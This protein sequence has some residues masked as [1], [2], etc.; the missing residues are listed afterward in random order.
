MVTYNMDGSQRMSRPR[1]GSSVSSGFR[2]VDADQLDARS[3]ISRNSIYKLRIDSMFDDTRSIVSQRLDDRSSHNGRRRSSSIGGLSRG[4]LAGAIINDRDNLDISA[5]ASSLRDFGGAGGV[6]AGK[7]GPVVAGPAAGPTVGTG[8]GRQ[9]TADGRHE[10]SNSVQ[11]QIER[12]FTDVAKEHG[13]SANVQSFSVRCLGSLPLKEKVTSLVGLQEPLRQLYLSGAGHG[14]QTGG[15]LDISP[16]GL[17]IRAGSGK[18][19]SVTPFQNIA[20]WSAVK[21]VVSGAEGGAAFLPLI[22]DPENIDKSSLFRPLSAAD[23]RRLSSGIHSP[24]FAIVMR[25]TL[26]PRQLEC[27]GFVCQ[28]P[29]DAIVIAATLYQSL[30][31]HMSGGDNQRPKRPKNRNGVSCMSIASSTVTTNTHQQSGS[32]KLSSRRSSASQRSML[33]P[34]PRPPRMKRSATSSLSGESDTV[35]GLHEDE[36]STEERRKKNLKNKRP[37][38][39]PPNPPRAISNRPMLDEIY[40][41]R[42]HST[43]DEHGIAAKEGPYPALTDNS[44]GDIL[45]RVAIPRSGSFLNTAGLT[46][47]KSRA[48]RRHTGKV[49]GGG[50]S[51]LGFSELFNEFRLQENLHSLDEILNAIINSDG[52][53]FNDLKPIYKEFL[54][55][56]AV[57]LT[58][59]ELYQ[60][61]KS[62][63]RRQK[64]KKLKRRN[65]NVQNQRR[66][67]LI[68]AKGLRKVFRFGKFRS[69]KGERSSTGSSGAAHGGNGAAGAG[70][71]GRAGGHHGNGAARGGTDGGHGT[72][73]V[74]GGGGGGGRAHQLADQLSLD[75]KATGKK[76]RSRI[77]TSGSEV[78]EAR[79]EHTLTAHNRNSS[80]GYVSCSECSYDSDACT[81]TSA[82]RCYCSLGGDD[83]NAKLHQASNR[84]SAPSCRSEDKCYCS[85]GETPNE[86]GSTTWCDTDSCISNEK[87]YCS[88]RHGQLAKCGTGGAGH[89][90]GQSKQAGNKGSKVDKL[91][92]D[93]ELFTV[94]GA[95][96]PV[97]ASEALSVKKTVEVAAE[98]ADVKLSQTTDITNLKSDPQSSSATSGGSSLASTTKK[99]S[100][101]H[102]HRGNASGRHHGHNHHHTHHR[103]QE[104]DQ[105]RLNTVSGGGG[106]ASGGGGSSGSL[107]YHRHHYSTSTKKKSLPAMQLPGSEYQYIHSTQSD[108]I[109]RS[110]K[111]QELKG[112]AKR[113][114]KSE[115]YYQAGR[116]VSS[117]LGLE[118]SLGYLP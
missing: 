19:P 2:L 61:S 85:M 3:S 5:V 28:T 80:S 7:G 69:K 54:L 68:G 11:A 33:P 41:D 6:A 20:V 8:A 24:L 78:S 107:H 23:K 109:V 43:G 25:S 65:S 72:A 37:P 59:D 45:T 91:A 117:S 82:D 10:I 99:S 64:K 79:H 88:T 39:I 26:V 106:G 27:H 29:E 51:P 34:P 18:E 96:R 71:N 105:K 35:P 108:L 13:T 57:T 53:S 70:G 115:S 66:K 110:S 16:I 22:T 17:R 62:I 98:F 55:K 84:S 94:G 74:A 58:K 40:T 44:T 31:A 9:G 87:C 89:G 95:G 67:L 12:M 112:A 83:I 116:P 14:T 75:L 77:G 60:R 52:M 90:Q 46:R 32:T 38:P 50:G 103:D 73:T 4:S 111:H 1:R 21:F 100:T 49:G 36:S 97:K 114:T 118:D 104:N 47:Y 30:M 56:L 93:Y 113:L 15:S 102:H 81:C 92:L 101:D 48:T 63:M 42:S 76:D 86:D